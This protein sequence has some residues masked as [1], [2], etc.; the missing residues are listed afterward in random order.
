[1]IIECSEWIFLGIVCIIL[2]KEC[3][4]WLHLINFISFLLFLAENRVTFWIW[5]IDITLLNYTMIALLV[6]L[7]NLIGI[8][9]LITILIHLIIKLWFTSALTDWI[10]SIMT[11]LERIL[12][13]SFLFI[14]QNSKICTV[15]S[16]GLNLCLRSVDYLIMDT[17]NLN[18]IIY[19]HTV[20]F[21]SKRRMKYYLTET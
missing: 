20:K 10:L 5:L 13:N 1:M 6:I 3:V 16:L 17:D 15:F 21:C 7:V 12:L 14:L 11:W 2:H 4:H 9:I 19:L 18:I 8:N